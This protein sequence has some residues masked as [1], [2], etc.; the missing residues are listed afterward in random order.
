MLPVLGAAVVTAA[1]PAH[2]DEPAAVHHVR[3]VVSAVLANAIT[4]KTATGSDSVPID[5]K[6]RIV[7][8]V[9]ATADEITSG[10]FIGTANVPGATSTSARAL[11]VV[12][13]PASMAGAGEG[14]Y[15]WDLPAGGGHSSMTNGTVAPSHTMMTNGTVAPSHTMMTNG[16]VMGVNNRGSKIVTLQYKGGSKMVTIGPGIPVVRMVA[17]SRS[18]LASGAHVVVAPGP[19]GAA[20]R[21]VIVGE[22]GA[23]PPM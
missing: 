3:G 4:V 13:F 9:P 14:D 16:T 8:V 15:A 11:E 22:Q 18:L 17:G 7:G 20:A 19:S 5:A 21:A 10:T 12:V 1:L 2:A 23:V 6:T